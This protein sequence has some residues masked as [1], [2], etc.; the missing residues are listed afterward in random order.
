MLCILLL[1]SWYATI[2]NYYGIVDFSVYKRYTVSSAVVMHI[3]NDKKLQI[4]FGNVLG[5]DFYLDSI[6][7]AT[8]LY[9]FVT[10]KKLVCMPHMQFVY[11]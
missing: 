9:V 5:R 10:I 11:T 2:Y 7:V 8:R 3:S 4:T 6:T 1:L